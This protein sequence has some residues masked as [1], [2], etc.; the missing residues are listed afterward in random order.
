MLPIRR[1]ISSKDYYLRDGQLVRV[2]NFFLSPQQIEHI[3]KMYC[4]EDTIYAVYETYDTSGVRKRPMEGFMYVEFNP[5]HIRIN[6]LGFIQSF[7]RQIR[8]GV[9]KFYKRRWIEFKVIKKGS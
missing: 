6:V 5:R 8:F 3:S 7:E 9:Y 1:L 4:I 2:N